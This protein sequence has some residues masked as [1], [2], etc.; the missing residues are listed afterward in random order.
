MQTS[1]TN[2]GSLEPAQ[3]TEM[4]I[5]AFTGVSGTAS[6][7]IPSI[8]LP[9]KEEDPFAGRKPGKV[10]VEKVNGRAAYRVEAAFSIGP[11]TYWIDQQTFLLVKMHSHL[12]TNSIVMDL[13]DTF[14][15]VHTNSSIP[16]STFARPS[17]AQ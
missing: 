13:T 9:I 12:N 11:T 10:T 6:M 4:A 16:A 17:G 2:P 7:T 1:I 5:A 14:T 8:V 3:S 15:D